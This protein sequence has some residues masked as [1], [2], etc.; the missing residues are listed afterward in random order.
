PTLR[1]PRRWPAARRRGAP[2]RRGRR[3]IR[4]RCETPPASAAAGGTRPGRRFSWWDLRTLKVVEDQAPGAQDAGVVAQ[5]GEEQL[6]GLAEGLLTHF[7]LKVVADQVPVAT[8]EAAGED[9]RLR[10]IEVGQVGDADP[11]VA[12]RAEDEGARGAVAGARPLG[13]FFRGRLVVQV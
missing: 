12:R 6:D 1:G 11:Q 4:A 13:D 9:H 5:R 3:P 2:P 10:V 7:V 8:R